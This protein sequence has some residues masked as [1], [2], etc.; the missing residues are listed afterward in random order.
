MDQLRDSSPGPQRVFWAA[1]IVLAVIFILVAA[2]VRASEQAPAAQEFLAVL[3]IDAPGVKLTGEQ[4]DAITDWVRGAARR[5]LPQ[6]TIMT[7]EN[8]VTLLD[9]NERTI[10][11]CVVDCEMEIGRL[12]GAD[13]IVTGAVT[14]FDD[15]LILTLGLHAT[16]SGAFLGS[17]R[18][19]SESLRELVDVVDQVGAELF[20]PLMVSR[21]TERRAPLPVP[22]TGVRELSPIEERP[23]GPGVRETS[24]IAAEEGHLRIEGEPPGATVSLSGPASFGVRGEDEG[25]LPWGPRAVPVGRYTAVV[26]AEGYDDARRTVEILADRTEVVRVELV[27][28]F[29]VLVVEG[30][31]R[32]AR[33]E[34]ECGSVTETFGLPGRLTVPRGSCRVTV[35]QGGYERFERTVDVPGGGEGK[36][37]VALVR[38][39]GELSVTGE[40]RGARVDLR[41]GALSESFGLPGRLT[42]PRGRCTVVVE[43]SGYERFERTVE[44]PGGGEASVAVRLVERVAAAPPSPTPGRVSTPASP[45]GT[46]R[47]PSSGLT[48][49][50]EPTGGR[51]RG[52]RAKSHCSG[53]SLAGGGWRLPTIG[54]LRSLVRGCA[55]TEVGGSCNV[56]EG[57][58]L[59]RGCRDS[60][61]NGCSRNAGPAD[62]C[63]WPAAMLGTCGW[64]WSSSPVA[65]NGALAWDVFFHYGHVD[66]YYVYYGLHV[67]CVR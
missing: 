10:E 50:V 52:S 58:C 66:A 14:Q 2:P 26:E 46:W 54:E 4:L 59:A 5:A 31:P 12:L 56:E 49:Q 45:A 20:A 24:P 63:Y 67:R 17:A 65:D 55:A 16:A 33:V 7:R 60:S 48:W 53:L 61:C 30:E 64:Y 9:A 57:D 8:V 13:Y 35:S 29:G 38:S 47:D 51:I 11:E 19:R 25:R 23:V 15:L 28:Q 41:C 34:F 37:S 62:G 3:E 39:T 21:P 18:G 44:I 43:R 6:M 1:G 40:P 27:S 36:V 32:G 42:V 22:G